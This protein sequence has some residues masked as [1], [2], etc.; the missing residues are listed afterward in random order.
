MSTAARG[1]ALLLAVG[2]PSVAAAESAFSSGVRLYET[3][4]YGGALEAFTRALDRVRSKSKLA[5]V[6]MYIGLIQVQFGSTGDAVNSFNRALEYN[7]RVRVPDE[8]PDRVKKLFRN[9]RRAARKKSA[10]ARPKKKKDD[11]EPGAPAPDPPVVAA[12]PAVTSRAPPDEA[13]VVEPSV[14]G[15][16]AVEPP[17]VETPVPV[18]TLKPPPPPEVIAQPPLPE[19]TAEAPPPASDGQLIGGWIGIGVGAAG[20]ATGAAFAVIARSTNADAFG[21]PVANAAMELHD[22]A[23]AQQSISFISLGV[24]AVAVGVGTWLLLTA[25]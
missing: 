11:P 16:S 2:T 7:M 13:P 18:D 25:D 17:P 6:H 20:L 5:R 15:P 21:E 19:V 24:G 4:D 9:L 10:A 12:S 8:A 22:T 23:V 14:P 1:L 3:A